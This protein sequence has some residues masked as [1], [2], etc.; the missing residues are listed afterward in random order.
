MG[1]EFSGLGSKIY[2]CRPEDGKAVELNLGT[3][4]RRLVRKS[5]EERRVDSITATPASGMI[6]PQGNGSFVL[7]GKPKPFTFPASIKP[8]EEPIEFIDN[9]DSWIHGA[10]PSGGFSFTGTCELADGAEA[11]AIRDMMRREMP[12]MQ[13]DVHILP[14]LYHK[15]YGRPSRKLK[16]AMTHGG[17]YKR[18][19]K[20]KRKVIALSNRDLKPSPFTVKDAKIETNNNGEVLILGRGVSKTQVLKQRRSR[21]NYGRQY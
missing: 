19:T 14:S 10:P 1:E 17:Y 9:T 16:K 21:L 7:F 5:A 15:V 18:N 2:L 12:E 11:E 6:V 13:F 3:G 8:H 4:I 20:W